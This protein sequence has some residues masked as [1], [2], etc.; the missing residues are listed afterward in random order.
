MQASGQFVITGLE[1]VGIWALFA[2]FGRIRGWTLEEVALFYGMISISFAI[3]DALAR[4]F[5][6]FGTS[7]NMATSIGCCCGRDRRSCSCSAT[8]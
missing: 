1:F 7:S 4:G 5:D 2:R 6:Q 3:A 8:S